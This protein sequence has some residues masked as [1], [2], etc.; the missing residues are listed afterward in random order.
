VLANG[1]EMLAKMSSTYQTPLAPPENPARSAGS[2]EAQIGNTSED[3]I[4]R[5]R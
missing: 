4:M 2:I 1:E 5:R 3:D